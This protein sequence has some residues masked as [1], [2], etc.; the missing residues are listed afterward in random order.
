MI[1]PR[2]SNGNLVISN[3]ISERETEFGKDYETILITTIP[4]KNHI[5]E[6]TQ[7]ESHLFKSTYN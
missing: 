3:I 7:I 1:A 2:D 5:Q 6:H 4:P